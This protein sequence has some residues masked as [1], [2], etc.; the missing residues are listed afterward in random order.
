MHVYV[1]VVIVFNYFYVYVC[2]VE[3]ERVMKSLEVCKAFSE[4]FAISIEAALQLQH[5][6]MISYDVTALGLLVLIQYWCDMVG[7]MGEDIRWYGWDMG[8]L[9]ERRHGGM[10]SMD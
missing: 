9:L 5:T 3:V 8:E 4:V 10:E 2:F 7:D 6:C 1:F